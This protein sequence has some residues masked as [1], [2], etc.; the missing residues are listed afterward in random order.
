MI[1]IKDKMKTV[2]KHGGPLVGAA[3]A[4][5]VLATGCK[6]SYPGIQYEESDEVT[7]NVESSD[8]LPIMLTVNAP[9][10]SF[11]TRGTGAIDEENSEWKTRQTRFYVYAFLGNNE[12]YNGPVDY[13]QHATN[14]QNDHCLVDDPVTGHGRLVRFER[15]G[16]VTDADGALEWADGGERVYYNYTHQDYKYDFFLYHLDDA[17]VSNFSRQRDE[18]SFDVEIDGTQDIISGIASPSASDI[19][20]L[21]NETNK[22]FLYDI[23]GEQNYVYSTLLAHRGVHPNF[24]VQHELVRFRFFIKKGDEMAGDISISDI[25]IH[26]SDKARFTVAAQD[27]E[28]VGLDFAAYPK[29]TR[30]FHLPEK[31][32]SA[33]GSISYTPTDATGITPEKYDLKRMNVGEMVQIGDDLLMAPQC[34]YMLTLRCQQKIIQNGEEVIRT[35]SPLYTLSLQDTPDVPLTPGSLYNVNISV[36]GLQE[37]QIQTEGLEWKKGH[38]INLDDEEMTD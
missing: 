15:T 2:R 11:A 25:I 24:K 8:S 29:H 26:G 4:F 33:D 3:C 7:G 20:R 9:Q 37:I 36:Y 22:D 21:E 14:P 1:E 13:T 18:I 31:N 30:D 17:F 19:E 35:F 12:F 10:L 5:L 6:E 28:K 38:D 27:A 32:V 34:S 16:G 23:R